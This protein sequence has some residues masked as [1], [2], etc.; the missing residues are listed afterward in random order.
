[1]FARTLALFSLCMPLI[2]ACAQENSPPR[3]EYLEDTNIVVGDE[4]QVLIFA[5]DPD[6][7]ALTFDLEQ[8]PEGARLENQGNQALFRW[9][10]LITQAETGGKS[11]PVRVRVRDARGASVSQDWTITAYFEG[12]I[13][14]FITPPG[15]VANMADTSVVSFLVEV[16]DDDDVTVNLSLASGVEGSLF[17]QVS[18]KVGSFYW[19]PTAEQRAASSFWSVVVTAD[20]GI[21]PVVQQTISIILINAQSD[22]CPGSPPS[23]QHIALGDQHG[24]PP[25]EIYATATDAES[26]VES[27]TLE[28]RSSENEAPLVIEMAEISPGFFTGTIEAN[29][30]QGADTQVFRYRLLARDNDDVTGSACD[31][32]VA[33]PKS[34]ELTFVAYGPNAPNDCKEDAFE[35]NDNPSSAAPLSAGVYSAM[36]SCGG[37]DWYTFTVP[38]GRSLST[39]LSLEP[40][41]GALVLTLG[42]SFGNPL[43]TAS[44]SG[45]QEL[46]Y[47][48]VLEDSSITIQV[49]PQNE[50]EMTYALE[51][52][53][54]D[55]GCEPDVLEPNNGAIGA[56]QVVTGALENLNI[57]PGDQ[58]W[59]AV[60]LSPGDR[61]RADV[62][63]EQSGGDL[64]LYLF[65]EDGLTSLASAITVT[66]DETLEYDA[67]TTET[68]FI[69]VSGFS[70]ASN[71]Y[72]LEVEIS[73]Q[74]TDCKDDLLAPN[75]TLLEAVPLTMGTL[76]GLMACPNAP[77]YF[78]YS[79][80]GGEILQV[81]AVP[82]AT[83]EAPEVR[84]LTATGSPLGGT[85]GFLNP[86]TYAQVTAMGSGPVYM[87][88]S[89]LVGLA[90]PYQL[91]L[92]V[93]EPPGSCNPDRL[94]LNDV[95]SQAKPI[96]GEVTSHL[97]LCQGDE[98]WLYFETATFAE[99]EIQAL[100]DDH[101]GQLKLEL[102]AINGSLLQTG[103]TTTDKAALNAFL[104]DPGA[105]Y[106]RVSGATASTIVYDLITSMD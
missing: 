35:P 18:G 64:D 81:N 61:L 57:C 87:V 93:T 78:V 37:D 24:P 1:M 25:F 36:R 104:E 12:G 65:A 23:I 51:L 62:L 26:G 22:S 44:F 10:P 70:T 88:V 15:F 101:N 17:Q 80:N 28:W 16:K 102:Y 5:S 100:F 60:E 55:G 72:R 99:V 40:E 20:D 71:S 92:V 43:K 2:L 94:E 21:H 30:V 66:S 106:I 7:D 4:L 48:P 97:T 69:V 89:P 84:L 91:E 34:A 47:G 95:L 76:N 67:Y 98:D 29:P 38:T 54:I 52:K 3:L 46:I 83:A 50:V 77:D 73:D 68:V 90:A 11:Y 45:S 79:L 59:F 13:P 85:Q 42:D 96:D 9:A 19:K 105:Y 14:T 82:T 41:H 32:I 31:H 39:R 86:G 33:I 58:D 103:Y 6:G 75:G 8:A 56:K 53:V 49:A 27:M 63:F 74:S